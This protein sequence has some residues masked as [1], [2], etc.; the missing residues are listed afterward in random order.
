MSLLSK[1]DFILT[2]E[3]TVLLCFLILNYECNFYTPGDENRFYCPSALPQPSPCYAQFT[4]SWLTNSSDH[5][6][7][8]H[9]I[10]NLLYLGNE[11]RCVEGKAPSQ[12]L[13]FYKKFKNGSRDGAEEYT[14]DFS[15][16]PKT[17]EVDMRYFFELLTGYQEA[18]VEFSHKLSKNITTTS[19]KL[20]ASETTSS[21]V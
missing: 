17:I 20:V 9:S 21:T 7:S 5:M 16:I 14:D 15:E 3:Y 6:L 4:A 10:V 18:V 12:C 11:T 19:H 8:S 2:V 1:G 13:Y